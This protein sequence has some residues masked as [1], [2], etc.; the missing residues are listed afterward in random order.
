MILGDLVPVVLFVYARPDLLVQTLEGLRA[1]NIPLLYVYCD[2]PADDKAR[3]A[4]EDVRSI[5]RNVDWC[6]I[7]LKERAENFGLGRSVL[8]GV[9]EV[10]AEHERVIV[11]ED[12][13]VLASG[14][15][16]YLCAALERYEADEKVFSIAAHLYDGL[17]PVANT[18]DPFFCGRFSCLGWAT[19]RRA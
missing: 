3:K 11:V 10:L 15:Y 6:E 12:D 17:I 8:A 16:T 13:I 1:N 4:T 5:V 9:S 7:V 19:W 14:T 18:R 2:G